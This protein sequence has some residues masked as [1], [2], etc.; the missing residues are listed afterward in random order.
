ME[1]V[2]WGNI[3]SERYI[4][5]KNTLTQTYFLFKSGG[6]GCNRY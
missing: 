1:F 4:I 5:K 6:I 3:L 2:L